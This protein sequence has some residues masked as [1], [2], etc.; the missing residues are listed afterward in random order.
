MCV[1]GVFVKDG[2][3]LL[4]KRNVEPF[5]GCW[6]LIGGHVEDNESLR[7]ALKKENSRKKPVLTLKWA[8]L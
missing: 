6:H 1:D 4:L 5:K 3:I 7:E 8:V 2:A